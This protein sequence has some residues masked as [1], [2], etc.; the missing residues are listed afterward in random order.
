MFLLLFIAILGSTWGAQR[1]HADIISAFTGTWETDYVGPSSYDESYNE[2]SSGPVL[3]G[4]P[5]VAPPNVLDNPNASLLMVFFDK[6]VTAGTLRTCSTSSCAESYSG[7]FVGG[8]LSMY[9]DDPAPALTATIT[10]GS[11]DGIHLSPC[12]YECDD[13]D[14]QTIDFTGQWAKTGW[15]SVGTLY[16]YY[17]EA[18]SGDDFGYA[19]VNMTTTTAPTTVPEPGGVILLGTGMVLVAASLRF[20]VRNSSPVS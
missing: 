9:L 5:N 11:Y 16:I 8:T 17:T 3:I 20:R 14:E 6:P 18:L 12:M 19:T 10:G 7:T 15:T 13:Y 1:A 4:N 2:N